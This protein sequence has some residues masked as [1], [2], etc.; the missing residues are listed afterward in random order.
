MSGKSIWAVVA[1]LLFT[2]IVTTLV[3]V[4]LHATGV[5][6][7]WDQPLDDRLSLIALSYRIVI[8]IAGGWITARLAPSAPMKHAMWLG[9]VGTVLGFAGVVA[10]WNLGMGPHWYPV[11]IAVLG[12]P[13]CWVGGMLAG[14]RNGTKA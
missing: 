1:G 3:D 14:G 8:T 11:A 6:A 2:I 7:A 13:E 4:V 10:T 5:Y 12:L 9:A